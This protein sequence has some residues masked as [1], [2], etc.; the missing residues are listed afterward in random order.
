MEWKFNEELPIYQQIIEQLKT[1]IAVG[2]LKP[3]DRLS[4]VRE[5]AV[6]AG[7]NPNTMQKALQELEREGLLY[8]ARTS[9]R[10]VAENKQYVENIHTELVEQY[11]R[12]FTENMAKVGYSPEQAAELYKDYVSRESNVTFNS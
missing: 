2:R 4:P 6:E 3:G 7:V 12:I 9:G 11:M 1:Q 8:T 5:L 10:F